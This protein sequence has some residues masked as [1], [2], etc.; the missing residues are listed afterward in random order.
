MPFPDCSGFL[1]SGRMYPD[2]IPYFA[3]HFSGS[4]LKKIL[5][6][7]IEVVEKNR[8]GVIVYPADYGF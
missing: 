7:N 8:A 6:S 4:F 3:N 1:L 5:T 2:V